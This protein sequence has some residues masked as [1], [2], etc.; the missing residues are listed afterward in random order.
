ML[1]GYGQMSPR[2][3]TRPLGVFGNRAEQ[4]CM[5]LHQS[6]RRFAVFSTQNITISLPTKNEHDKQVTEREK[7]Q[8]KKH[9]MLDKGKRS[10]PLQK[11]VELGRKKRVENI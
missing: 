10:L 4:L 6:R 5:Y 8:Q 11:Q 9:H 1:V 3:W 2:P 7:V